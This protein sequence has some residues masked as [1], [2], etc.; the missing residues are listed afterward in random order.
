MWMAYANGFCLFVSLKQLAPDLSAGDYYWQ[1]C[2]TDE[3]ASRSGFWTETASL[4]YQ[5]ACAHEK[6]KDI[7]KELWEI[8]IHQLPN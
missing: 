5:L 6:V 4:N 8:L 3:T 2:W 1:L 7:H